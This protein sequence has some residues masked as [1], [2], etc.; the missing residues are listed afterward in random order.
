MG[1]FWFCCVDVF[2]MSVAFKVVQ[3]LIVGLYEECAYFHCLLYSWM[4]IEEKECGIFEYNVGFS[5]CCQFMFSSWP[6]I[7]I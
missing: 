6:E 5:Y 7:L 1:G 2:S 3:F 4:L